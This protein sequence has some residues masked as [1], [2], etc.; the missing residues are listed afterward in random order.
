MTN[1]S[2]LQWLSL[3]IDHQEFTSIGEDPTKCSKLTQPE[4]LKKDIVESKSWAMLLISIR[5]PT[6]KLLEIKL[7]FARKKGENNL[8]LSQMTNNSSER[9][10]ATKLIRN[11]TTVFLTK[12][13]KSGNS[14]QTLS[15]FSMLVPNNTQLKIYTSLKEE[16]WSVSAYK[17]DGSSFGKTNKKWSITVFPTK[18]SEKSSKWMIIKFASCLKP[19]SVNRLRMNIK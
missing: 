16:S 7:L 14:N 11:I 8:E 19:Q 5:R 15:P 13:L 9:S 4:S 10:S 3:L 1:F 2:S 18:S 6:L 17:K 12:E